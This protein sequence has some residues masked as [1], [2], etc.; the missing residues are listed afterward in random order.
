MTIG[1]I[2]ANRAHANRMHR[3]NRWLATRSGQRLV[4]ALAP[5]SVSLQLHLK[6][7]FPHGRIAVMLRRHRQQV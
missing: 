4:R 6:D 2:K 7:R 5:R 1:Q 3:I